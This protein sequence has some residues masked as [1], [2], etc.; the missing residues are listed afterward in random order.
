M[1]VQPPNAT[2]F[3]PCMRFDFLRNI[4]F[5]RKTFF[6]FPHECAAISGIGADAFE[7]GPMS[8]SRFGRE[9][10][11]LG[12]VDIGGMNHHREQV[13]HHIDDNMAL[14]PF[15]FFPPSMPRCSLAAVVLTLCESIMP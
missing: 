2:Q 1:S 15:C 4:D 12:I 14:A 10:A 11:R 8:A 5:Q 6:E 13:A 7:T 3:L 9:H